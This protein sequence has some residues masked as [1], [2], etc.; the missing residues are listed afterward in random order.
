[1]PQPYLS[2]LLV[3]LCFV[4]VEGYNLLSH[5]LLICPA[6]SLPLGS[7]SHAVSMATQVGGPCVVRSQSDQW[8]LLMCSGKSLTSEFSAVSAHSG[9]L[10]W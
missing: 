6:K 1:M 9:S 7:G 3:V 10:M 2:K 4:L 8:Q 5:G